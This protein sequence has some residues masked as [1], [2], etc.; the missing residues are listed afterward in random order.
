M[1]TRQPKCG[2][3]K[4]ERRVEIDA[5]LSVKHMIAEVARRFE[6]AESPLRRHRD[7]GHHLPGAPASADSE[8]PPATSHQPPAQVADAP[9]SGGG[10]D[11]DG[12]Q[13]THEEQPDEEEDE[14][15]QAAEPSEPPPAAW[16]APQLRLAPA[17]EGNDSAAARNYLQ[18]NTLD[19]AL[20]RAQM[21][22]ETIRKTEP[23][24][25]ADGRKYKTA[26]T[27]DIIRAGRAA[28]LAEG[29]VLTQVSQ[30]VKIVS[31][32]PVLTLL[33]LLRYVRTNP[34]QLEYI[35]TDM[36]I[37]SD[38]SQ[39]YHFR[40]SSASTYAL[41]LTYKRIL[42]IEEQ[43]DD[44]DVLLP[45]IPASE[46]DPWGL[47]PDTP[48]SDE[49]REEHEQRLRDAH[50]G[51]VLPPGTDALVKK[52]QKDARGREF[53]Q[54]NIRKKEAAAASSRGTEDISE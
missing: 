37:P 38:K 7:Q 5:A 52:H 36:I 41:R 15:E 12:E 32:T 50:V 28:L 47:M 51:P 10:G 24:V 18:A 16:I 9:G 39:D 2:I 3:C 25:A 40:T 1:S 22:V 11:S 21:A 29:I 49:A 54:R 30:T 45:S 33:Y 4:Q 27:T 42:Q 48:I 34:A 35:E 8:Q 23:A 13:E 17:N 20:G 6:V 53:A 19:A 14:E 46:P 31:R 26:R 44:R 43:E